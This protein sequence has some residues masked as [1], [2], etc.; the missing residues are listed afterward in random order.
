MSIRRV[1]SL[2]ALVIAACGGGDGGGGP[3]TGNNGVGS[4]KGN[5]V[6]NSNAAVAGASVSL[7]ATGKSSLSAVTG[8][9]GS[10][11]FN[12][13][14][15]GAWQVTV[16]PPAGFVGGASP[17]VNVTANAQVTAT[18]IVLTKIPAGPAPTSVDVVITNAAVFSPQ[19]VIVAQNG[20]V[21]WQNSDVTTH[22][23]TGSAFDTGNILPGGFSAPKTFPTKGTFAYV[24]SIHPGMTGTVVV[25]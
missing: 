12:N 1:V 4:V 14:S 25:Q 22:T 23:A 13:V 20:T 9:D 3:I 2:L 15:T 19:T 6:D 21:R 10:Y 24:C 11:T 8:N 7:S 16:S 17:Q 18:T 5:V